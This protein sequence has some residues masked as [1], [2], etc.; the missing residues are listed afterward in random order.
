MTHDRH[1]PAKSQIKE[2]PIQSVPKHKM[3][4]F[5]VVESLLITP[6]LLALK[7]NSGLAIEFDNLDYTLKSFNQTTSEGMDGPNTQVCLEAPS[8]HSQ[9]EKSF[10]FA[11]QPLDRKLTRH[12][13]SHQQPLQRWGGLETPSPQHV[14]VEPSNVSNA[15]STRSHY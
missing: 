8:L 5:G 9:C 6:S 7:C 11:E 13:P 2:Y 1:A 3:H 10:Q 15:G 14:P 4:N 12:Q